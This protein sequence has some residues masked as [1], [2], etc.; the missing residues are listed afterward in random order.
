MSRPTADPVPLPSK[1]LR[2][3]A[4][5]AEVPH[6][7]GGALALGF[8]AEPRATIDIDLN[9][10]VAGTEFRSVMDAL[11]PLGV[12]ASAA[13]ADRAA[14]DGQ[15]RVSW[16]RTPIDLFFAYDPFHTEA[17][18][19]CRQVGFAGASIAVLAPEHLIACKAVF[20]RPKDWIDIDAILAAG[21]A[22]D[23]AEAIRWVGRIAG[24]T[25]RRYRRLVAVLTS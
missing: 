1:V 7:F 13:D 25:D 10:F 17:G 9:V 20:D 5:L 2:I 23:A 14:R 6:A 21:T 4:A 3:A 15:V 19:R 18:A 16:D 22:V 8:Y 12:G 11:E 24:D